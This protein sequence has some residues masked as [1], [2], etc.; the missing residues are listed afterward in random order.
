VTGFVFF[1][2]MNATET[3]ARLQAFLEAGAPPVVFTLGT[4]AIT[5]A[6]EFYRASLEAVRERGWRA[7]ILTGADPRNR[8]LQSDVPE[9]VFVEEYAPY[10]E[11]FSRAAVVVHPGGIGTIA[12][13]LRAGVPSVV[14]P[15][16]ADQPDNAYRLA[17]LGA[18]RTITRGE[19]SARRVAAELEVVL[20]D[21]TYR[22]CAKAV[23]REI[24]GEDG[25]ARACEALERH[26]ICGLSPSS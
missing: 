5:V 11:V 20:G 19:Y 22:D 21:S 24:L 17:R 10:R 9:S 7:V 2:E 13:T 6:G 1:D 15:F 25:L 26:A 16:A 18:S 12:Q 3:D 4:S 23:S 8:I 14:V